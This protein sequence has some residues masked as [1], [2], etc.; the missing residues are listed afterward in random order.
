MPRRRTAAV[1]LLSLLVGAA[2]T[3]TVGPRPPS[4]P[5]GT[6]ADTG[7]P[8][9]AAR[10]HEV[11]GDEK[12]Y[13]GVAVALVSADGA[14]TFAGVGG[15]RDPDRPAVDES[16]R[17]EIGSVTKGLTGMLL[18]EQVRRGEV[19]LDDRVGDAT[20]SELAT[21][22]SGLPRQ[23]GSGL[24]T[25]ALT[26][27]SG[28]DPYSGD[29]AEVLGLASDADPEGGADPV[30]SNVGGAAAGDLVAARA[31]TPYPELLRERVLAPLGMDE[32]TV[33]TSEGDLPPDRARGTSASGVDR[34]P[35]IAQGWAPAG[36]G[37]WSTTSDMARLVAALADGGAPG[38]IAADPATAFVDDDR[39][40]LFWITKELRGQQVTWHDGGTGGFR[41]FVGFDRESGRGVVVLAN[42]DAD[43]NAGAVELLLEGRP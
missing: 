3:L 5:S 17:F 32:T 29:A 18:A 7:D 34:E 23:A 12:G 31:R 40:G 15:S 36:I 6:A 41:S 16:T 39:I 14:A 11:F 43:V 10:V 30:Y 37:V 26:G 22:R 33:V 20:L 19:S 42:T 38:A 13:R 21:H 28:G 25:A 9:L 24:V 35:W 2:A 4:L 27:F 8:A 1:L